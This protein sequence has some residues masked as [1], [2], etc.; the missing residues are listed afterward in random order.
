MACHSAAAGRS[1]CQGPSRGATTRVVTIQPSPV[2]TTAMP[3]LNHQLPTG[4]IVQPGLDQPRPRLGDAQNQHVVLA[5]QQIAGEPNADAGVAD[6][7]AEHRVPSGG[8]EDQ[9]RERYEDDVAGIERMTRQHARQHHRGHEHA[10][11]HGAKPNPHERDEQAAAIGDTRAQ[12]DRERDA[13]RR[14]R[15]IGARDLGNEQL[16]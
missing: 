6:R 11:R 12:H 9:A 5:R 3:M 13:E 1:P 10:L 2:N 7:E 8:R 16:Q 14:E 15:R 4:F